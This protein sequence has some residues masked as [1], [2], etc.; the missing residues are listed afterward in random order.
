ML[1]E[2]IILPSVLYRISQ[3]LIG[4]TV[5]G[6]LQGHFR[7]ITH[8]RHLKIITAADPQLPAGSDPHIRIR[9]E[10]GFLDHLFRSGLI[11][12]ASGTVGQYLLQI[13]HLNQD[14]HILKLFRMGFYI[15]I[16]HLDIVMQLHIQAV[17]V[18]DELIY[19]GDNGFH[20][21]HIQ[22]QSVGGHE[23]KALRQLFPRIFMEFHNPGIQP[24]LVISV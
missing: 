4:R 22:K 20:L 6:I 18:D 1:A 12:R 14:I 13:P 19:V 3:L 8:I 2:G 10:T 11:G 21:F 9:H 7:Q 17:I 24:G 5:P 23:N 15:F 16:N